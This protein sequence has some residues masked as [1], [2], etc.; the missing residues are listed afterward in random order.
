MGVLNRLFEVEPSID[1]MN[2]VVY[3]YPCSGKEGSGFYVE[4][5]L[6]ADEE[7]ED[8]GGKKDS[9]LVLTN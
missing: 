4:D 7:V 2:S 3:I 6:F 1:E 8:G 9:F 5:Y